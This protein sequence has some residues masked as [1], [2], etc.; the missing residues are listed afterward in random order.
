M[1]DDQGID[2]II[3]NAAGAISNMEPAGA[4]GPALDALI[5]GRPDVAQ[6]IALIQIAD[7]LATI[8]RD[9][10][11]NLHPDETGRRDLGRIIA[12]ALGD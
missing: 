11:D 10:N 7:S 9:L 3:G 2:D 8:A 5:A 6:A 4:V 1:S 12:D